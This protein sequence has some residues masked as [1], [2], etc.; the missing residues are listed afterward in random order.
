MPGEGPAAFTLLA[1]PPPR[2]NSALTGGYLYDRQITAA[3]ERQAQR[4]DGNLPPPSRYRWVA[5]RDLANYLER[6]HGRSGHLVLL[7]SLFFA[8]SA[9]AWPSRPPLAAI[10][11]LCHVVPWR[12]WPHSSSSHDLSW[13]AGAVTTSQATAAET[14]LGLRERDCRGPALPVAPGV[15]LDRFLPRGDVAPG[16]EVRL[17]TVANLHRD[18][19]QLFL[20][21]A[22]AEVAELRWRWRI[23]G[24][25]DAEP[26]TVD[27]FRRRAGR[28]GLA[29]RV[30][31]AGSI[32]GSQLVSAYHHAD[33]A[34][35]PT[36]R[37][38]YGMAI[39]E[40]LACQLPVLASDVGGVREAVGAS[41]GARL[42]HAR[43]KAAWVGALRAVIAD[44]DK[45]ERLRDGARR[46]RDHLRGWR[47][48]GEAIVAA[49]GTLLGAPVT[50]E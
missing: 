49:A 30:Q 27:E 26:D 11:L 37:E 36:L 42:V 25:L 12:F 35:F 9:L 46:G 10:A 50:N 23:V 48:A 18:K 8:D 4:R 5:P 22:L 21:D 44:E 7:D 28:L 41:H 39:T 16:D 20:L 17:V 1:P 38:S 40:A 13:L 2:S 6:T 43:D 45:R 31:L 29:D 33:V 14:V 34:L 32:A 3:V 24:D 15:D 47:D 19:G